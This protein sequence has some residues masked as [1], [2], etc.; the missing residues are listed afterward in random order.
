MDPLHLQGEIRRSLS[1][2]SKQ[3]R[4]W[5]SSILELD[6]GMVNGKVL[7]WENLSIYKFLIDEKVSLIIVGRLR[8][9][10]W[11]D[12]ISRVGLLPV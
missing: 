9:R 1:C 8:K 10:F 3:I 11:R 5:L 7:I 4:H 6:S 2:D 12:W